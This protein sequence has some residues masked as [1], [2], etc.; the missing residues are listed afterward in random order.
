[1]GMEL[2]HFRNMMKFLVD[3][4]GNFPFQLL[5]VSKR[6]NALVSKIKSKWLKNR[7]LVSLT[8]VPSGWNLW[9]P[10][11]AQAER[12]SFRFITS[13]VSH[14]LPPR[15]QDEISYIASEVTDHEDCPWRFTLHL[16]TCEHVITLKDQPVCEDHDV[17]WAWIESVHFS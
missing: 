11:I 17:G 2:D 5:A 15:I 13:Q 8:C 9:L 10:R 6:T 1:M 7:L 4:D 16:V 14:I 3:N 12:I